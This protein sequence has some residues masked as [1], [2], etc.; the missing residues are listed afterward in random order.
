MTLAFFI[1]ATLGSL[2]I[3]KGSW[4]TLP[5][6]SFRELSIGLFVWDQA[7]C[8]QNFVPLLRCHQIRRVGTGL[9]LLMLLKE[10]I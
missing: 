8:Q 3:P 5:G 2:W 9:W 10:F 7:L 6:G 1:V 4:Y